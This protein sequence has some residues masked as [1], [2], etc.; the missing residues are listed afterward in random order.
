MAAIGLWGL[1]T[2]IRGG[3]LEGSISGSL[4]IA[5]IVIGI[6]GLFGLILFAEGDRP[7]DSVHIL[8]GFAAFVTM[9]FVWSYVRERHPRQGLFF[10]SLAVDTSPTRRSQSKYAG[11]HSY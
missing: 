9:P 6:Q 10:Y 3:T 11:S 8:Y 4:V 1:F 2:F 5:Q 7:Q